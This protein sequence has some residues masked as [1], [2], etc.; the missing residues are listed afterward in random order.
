MTMSDQPVEVVTK[1]NEILG[2][3]SVM[4]CNLYRIT[5]TRVRTVFQTEI[6]KLK[7]QLNQLKSG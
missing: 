6:A 3:V 7:I 5:D 4:E 1:I 2:N